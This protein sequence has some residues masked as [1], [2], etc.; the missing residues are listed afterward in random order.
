MANLTPTLASILAAAD[1]QVGTG[2]AG[3]TITQGDVLVLNTSTNRY[4]L[5]D[6]GAASTALVAGIALNAASSTQPIKFIKSG[7]LTFGAA[8]CTAGAP[9]FLSTTAGLLMDTIPATGNQAVLIAIGLTTSTM[10]VGINN[11]QVAVP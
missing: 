11:S 8:T 5:A 7:T 2:T 3:T 9:Y 1:V 10:Q 4:D 6:D